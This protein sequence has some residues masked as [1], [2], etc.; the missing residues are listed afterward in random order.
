MLNSSQVRSL[1]DEIFSIPSKVS[2][3]YRRLAGMRVFRY[4][5]ERSLGARC[6]EVQHGRWLGLRGRRQW[7][8]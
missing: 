5:Y 3:P 1:P 6:D 7:G 8:K 4:I 2:K